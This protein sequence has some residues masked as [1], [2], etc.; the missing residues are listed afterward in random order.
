[1]L[2]RFLKNIDVKVYCKNAQKQG[3]I[4]HCIVSSLNLKEFFITEKLRIIANTA[5]I[6]KF[7]AYPLTPRRVMI[8]ICI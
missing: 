5:D 2:F 1:M 6:K 8:K 3:I 7:K 4:I